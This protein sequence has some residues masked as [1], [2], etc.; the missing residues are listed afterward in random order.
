M[1]Y[2][3]A[4][5]YAFEDKEWTRK[6][7]IFL[8]ILL[9][10]ILNFAGIGY[11]VDIMRRIIK[12]DPQPLPDWD[13]L[14]KKFMD[15]LLLALASIIYALPILLLACLPLALILVPIFLS[16][17]SNSQDIANALGG[18]SAIA[19]ACLGCFA[20][21]YGLALSVLIPAIYV[22]YAAE[23]TFASCFNFKE[24]FAVIRRNTGAY[25]TAWI[26]YVG[27]SFG[28]SLVG[29]LIGGLLSWIPC[30]G[31]LAVFAIS[32]AAAEYTI[33][34]FSHMFGQYSLLPPANAQ[35]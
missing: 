26:V 11:S 28:A 29:G 35:G 6:L 21:V 12:G 25:F 3:R 7:G 27:I 5:T 31:Q 2:G 22:K 1:N 13:D 10:P 8:V 33:L 4:F 24:I 23:G 16:G 32:F 18:A 9:V 20:F 14:G 34:V 30:I 17:N 15:G 19:F